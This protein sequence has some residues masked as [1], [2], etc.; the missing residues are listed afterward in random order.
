MGGRWEKGPPL[1][2]S[3]GFRLQTGFRHKE[4]RPRGWVAATDTWNVERRQA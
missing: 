1:G 2:H 4:V 3:R